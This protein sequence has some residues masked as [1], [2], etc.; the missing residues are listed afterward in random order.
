MMTPVPN[1]RARMIAM[2]CDTVTRTAEAPTM[3][4]AI[5]SAVRSSS[6][7]DA[8]P[9]TLAGNVLPIDCAGYGVKPLLRVCGEWRGTCDLVD[10]PCRSGG[11]NV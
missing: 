1:D 10:C 8:T 5:P 9:R 2:P 11:A 4:N 3:T 6:S 7:T